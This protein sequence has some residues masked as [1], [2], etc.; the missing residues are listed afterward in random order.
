[1][2]MGMKRQIL[3]IDDDLIY[4]Q[5]LRKLL[6]NR[7]DVVSIADSKEALEYLDEIENPDLVIADLNLPGVDS[8]EFI[9]TVKTKL[10]NDSTH[11]LV[12]S[13]TDDD[14]LKAEL[15]RLGIDDVLTKPVHRKQ[16]V[17]EVDRL[18]G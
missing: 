11:I 13:G 14:K 1:M 17:E 7:Y 18:I 8:M 4:Q 9:S 15:L 2:S 16:L 6:Y 10:N 12:I 3:I 5:I